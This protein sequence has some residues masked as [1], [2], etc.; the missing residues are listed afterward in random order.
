[1]RNAA[2][3]STTRKQ[4]NKNMPTNNTQNKNK[5]Q[6]ELPVCNLYL[7]LNYVNNGF[8]QNVQTI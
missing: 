2:A 3:A 4:A 7:Q 5:L 6:I 1:M 8:A